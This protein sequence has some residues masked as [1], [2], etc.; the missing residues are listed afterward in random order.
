MRTHYLV[1]FCALIAMPC[2]AQEWSRTDTALEATYLALHSVDW[3]QS[4][5][6]AKHPE[7]FYE[8]N[9]FLGKHPHGGDVNVYFATTAIAHIAVAYLLPEKYRSM[10]QV[11]TIGMEIGYV[12][13]NY[14]I[15]IGFSF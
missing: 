13:K 15:G 1:A 11:A 5:Y 12:G 8:T 2:Q 7:S 9:V 3:S 6:I 4:K 14:H 10:F